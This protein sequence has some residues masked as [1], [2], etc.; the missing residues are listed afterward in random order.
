MLLSGGIISSAFSS[1]GTTWIEFSTSD[2]LL[3]KTT[4]K[5]IK[6]SSV[7]DDGQCMTPEVQRPQS[8]TPHHWLLVLCLVGLDYFST[9]AYL[10][11]L[12][13]AAAGVLA[14]LAAFAVVL[15]TLCVALPIYC[16]IVGRSA[17]GRGAV[18]LLEQMMP[19]WRGK[20]IVL[21]ML[22]FA[23]ADFV[24]TRSLSV[25]D[26][27]VHLSHNPHG[28]GL[29]DR[30]SPAVELLTPW[31][32][33]EWLVGL[34][35]LLT[36]QVAVTLGMAVLTFG[37]WQLLQRG[38]TRRV[39]WLAVTLVTIYLVSVAIVVG[40]GLIYVSS[41]PDLWHNWWQSVQEISSR[42][43]IAQHPI[44]GIATLSFL[45]LWAFPQLAIG[46]SGFEL[47]M[48]ITPLVRGGAGAARDDQNAR[49]A[50]TR[51]LLCAAAGIMALL[52]MGSVLVTT[53]LVP[54]EALA[55]D[56]LAE[57]RSLAY[58][59]HGGPLA[60]GERGSKL[61]SWF[62]GVFGSVFDASTIAVLSLAGASV[63]AGLRSMLP[64]YLHRLGMA[65]TWA[66][67]T[68]VVMHLLNVIILIVT[69]AFHA[70][71]TTQQWAYATS[72]LVL[73]AGAA[74]AAG[75]DV[76]RRLHR[77]SWWW[78][79][80]PPIL[81]SCTFFLAMTVVT[82]FMHPSGVILALSFVVTIVLT[83]FVSRWLRST[84]LRFEG[85]AFSNEATRI[86]WEAICRREFQVVVP[87][88]PGLLSL[89]DKNLQ[90]Q[91]DFRLNATIPILFVEATLGDPSEFYHQPLMTIHDRDG[92]EVLLVSKCV[93][94]SHVLASICLALCQPGG[95]PPEV[96]FGWSNE[97]PLAANLNFLLLG[98]GNI[99]WMVRE[100]VR[101]AVRD[102]R[103]QPRIHIG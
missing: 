71:I 86:R 97:R 17:S 50:N 64:H 94:I 100:L 24:I 85:F 98:E 25:A 1:P 75:L 14:P 9:L 15:I 31:V 101:H 76:W 5:S 84:E 66:G 49:I 82:T 78:F 87:H 4:T 42:G 35:P 58:L 10:P 34:R 88:R 47:T 51:K 74:L 23:A 33:A 37:F 54:R 19:G 32:P 41:H 90:I 44:A 69:V 59:A 28:L 73:V 68:G 2:P 18:G 67:Q 40:S 12:A 92:L 45:S 36:R 26:A 16:Y 95:R 62:G 53:L 91:R 65:L 43:S 80:V 39:L 21:T 77:L 52:V 6:S 20:L 96:I 7:F 27:A 70:S 38:F 48:T 99:P 81:L 57:D 93:S 13:V 56:G 83:S 55:P 11:S 89:S 46:L 22:G 61:N 102:V 8:A 3:T 79:F 103:L 30:M 63:V 72:V 60:D 29:I